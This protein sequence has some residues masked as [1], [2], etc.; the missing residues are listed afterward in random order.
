MFLH[1]IIHS[2]LCVFACCHL[3]TSSHI[4]LWCVLLRPQCL[5]HIRCLW[6][7]SLCKS[8]PSWFTTGRASIIYLFIYF[9][10]KKGINIH[11][12]FSWYRN[13]QG[14][15]KSNHIWLTTGTV[16]CWKTEKQKNLGS[17]SSVD[18]F[19]FLNFFHGM[20][21][22]H[23]YLKLIMPSAKAAVS[24]IA[25]VAVDHW[26]GDPSSCFLLLSPPGASAPLWQSACL[27]SALFISLSSSSGCVSDC[28]GA[29]EKRVCVPVKK[30]LNVLIAQ[31]DLC[32]PVR[33]C[34]ARACT[35]AGIAACA[36]SHNVCAPHAAGSWLIDHPTQTTTLLR[37]SVQ[38]ALE[39]GKA[40]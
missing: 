17:L 35:H 21:Q 38:P 11:F 10:Y 34:R 22:W 25:F 26:R 2:F 7:Q 14:E 5:S 8:S 33:V 4:W 15:A 16:N 40:S 31:R 3:W 39:I 18:F 30:S 27:C 13:P 9:L 23:Y 12:Y 37:P 1:M 24:Q 36:V 32:A 28:G 19:F 20:G 6:E 29:G